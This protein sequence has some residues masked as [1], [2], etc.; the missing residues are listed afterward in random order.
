VQIGNMGVSSDAKVKERDVD[1]RDSKVLAP[2][3]VD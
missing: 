2:I 3:C 1:I